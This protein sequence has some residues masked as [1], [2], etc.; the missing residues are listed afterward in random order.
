MGNSPI[1]RVPERVNQSSPKWI[2]LRCG[3]GC[4]GDVR[5]GRVRAPRRRGPGLVLY[6]R[7][8]RAAQGT[9]AS[10]THPDGVGGRVRRAFRPEFV[11]P[12]NPRTSKATP[13]GGAG[14]SIPPQSHPRRAERAPQTAVTGTT[15]PGRS[16]ADASWPPW[17]LS[18]ARASPSSSSSPPGAGPGAASP[19]RIHPTPASTS[20]LQASLCPAARRERA[21]APGRAPRAGHEGRR[22]VRRPARVNVRAC[23]PSSPGRPASRSPCACGPRPRGARA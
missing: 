3:S 1:W 20:T 6:Q 12:A 8:S 15:S 10:S 13:L 14:R 5:A 21:E 19:G 22:R 9:R 7:R 18:S 17:P 23:E 4:G 11:T 2:A 16:S